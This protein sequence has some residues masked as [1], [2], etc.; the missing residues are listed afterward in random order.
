MSKFPAGSVKCP[1]CKREVSPQEAAL[2]LE[3]EDP[4]QL[5]MW[6]EEGDDS[7]HTAV[8]R[9]KREGGEEVE[10]TPS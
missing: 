3:I 5:K 10:P 8:L 1:T 4:Q 7:Y 2:I 9:R 6:R